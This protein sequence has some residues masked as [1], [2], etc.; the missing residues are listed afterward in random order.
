[1]AG[2]GTT[3]FGT[4]GIRGV[5]GEPPLDPATVYAIGLALGDDLRA[6][7]P[8]DV[9]IGQDT[10]ESS[11]WIAE[12]LAAGLAAREMQT[13]SAGVITTPGIAYLTR[14]DDFAAGVMISASHNPYQDNGIKVFEHSGYKLPDADEAAVEAGI[15]RYRE[16]GLAPARRAPAEDA[17]LRRRY[18]EYLRSRV[19][20]VSLRG[21]SAV[22]DCGNG[23]ASAVAG[24]LFEGLGLRVHWL[25][26]RPDGRNINRDCGALHPEAMARAVTA[27]GADF[28]LALD[29]DADRAILADASGRL[30][31][32][33]RVLYV[34][35]RDLLA[36]G[37]LEPR[38]VVGT[39]MSNLGLEVALR[40]EQIAL[41]RAPV[42]DKYV[43]E[44]MLASGAVL[45]GEQSGHVI[46]RQD[47]TTGDG[48]LT[49]LRVL[50]IMAR[51][52]ESLA[53]LAEGFVAFP[54]KLVNVRVREKTPL[55][56]LAATGEAIR[57]AEA[58]FANGGQG[59]VLVRYSGTERLARIMVEAASQGEVER[60]CQAIARAL[61][62]E[63]GE[64]SG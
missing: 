39:V 18:V 52:G 31:D 46:F 6:H 2:S 7:G 33:D 1:M 51:R 24:E 50:E 30:V 55:E 38:V 45:G 3:Y 27:R 26:D 49:A 28:G 5:A 59:R 57:A 41:L 37:R 44:Q 13:A 11:G 54:Q 58:A 36:R 53:A 10:R 22:I 15:E 12:T 61:E 20:G 9:V 48:L 40:R 56:Q 14:T 43:L 60:H 32:G 17:G 47:A 16:Q 63:I 21:L 35:A 34:A 42:G 62:A 25:G 29:G 64:V 19:A 4:D 23:A 8:A